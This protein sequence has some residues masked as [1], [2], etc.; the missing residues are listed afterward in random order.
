MYLAR[1]TGATHSRLRAKLF[2][3]A[4]LAC[5]ISKLICECPHVAHHCVRCHLKVE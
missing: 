2:L 5:D 1:P 4:N 3:R